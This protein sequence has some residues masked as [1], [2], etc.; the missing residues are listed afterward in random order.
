M[1]DK[2]RFN[3]HIK[4]VSK[5][6]SKNLGVL[7]KLKDF[8]PSNT[9]LSVYRSIIESYINYCNLIFGNTSIT[10]LT[11]LVTAQKKAVRIVA[12]KPP[13]SH[14]NPIFF[15]LKLLKLTDLYK[16]NLGIYMW[17]NIDKFEDNFRVNTHNTRSGNHYV[18]TSFR[19]TM[20]QN[21]SIKFQAPQNWSQ[22]PDYIINSPSLT[23]FKRK[24]KSFLLSA[25]QDS[26]I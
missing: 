16:Y 2:L 12:K 4:E 5:K 14:T 11:P 15:D 13:L 25:Y 18:P 21:K 3:I 26:D 6:I 24:Y 10:H 17:K 7:Y 19:L 9:L 1:D 20:T 22:I 8:V 23:T